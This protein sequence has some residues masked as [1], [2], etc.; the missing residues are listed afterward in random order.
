MLTINFH[1]CCSRLLAI[2]IWTILSLQHNVQALLGQPTI[3]INVSGNG[4]A[5]QVIFEVPIPLIR[6]C[7]KSDISKAG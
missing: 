1:L 5:G 4:G 6:W 3:Y 2:F 7:A